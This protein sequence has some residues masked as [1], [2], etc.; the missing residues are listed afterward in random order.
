MICMEWSCC[1]LPQQ[2][3]RNHFA[4]AFDSSR[5]PHRVTALHKKVMHLTNGTRMFFFSYDIYQ[6][7]STNTPPDG[8]FR[9]LTDKIVGHQSR[10]PCFYYAL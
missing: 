3:A 1:A 2:G 4:L 5:P 9:Q 8:Y 7:A 10:C 6:I